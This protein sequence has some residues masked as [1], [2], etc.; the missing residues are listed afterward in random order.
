MASKSFQWVLG[1]LVL[2]VAVGPVVFFRLERLQLERRLSRQ[3]ELTQH[4]AQMAEENRAL[5][6]MVAKTNG[7]ASVSASSVHADLEAA[8]RELA[9][10]EKHAREQRKEVVA[11]AARDDDAL[12]NNR[13]PL[14]ALTRP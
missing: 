13:D 11:Q 3:R 2:G 7:D 14:R 6:E 9:A 10:L 12:A 1:A 4:S 8:R 5:R